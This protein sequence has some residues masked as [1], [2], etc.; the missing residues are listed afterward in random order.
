MDGQ[1]QDDRPN[2]GCRDA[3][4]SL[5]GNANS[6]TGMGPF[7]SRLVRSWRLTEAAE[8]QH[9]TR[10]KSTHAQWID[11]LPA[12]AERDSASGALFAPVQAE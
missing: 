12:G 5:K 9:A 3:A 10:R 8:S 2:R 1:G 7:A 6:V 11:Q 4:L